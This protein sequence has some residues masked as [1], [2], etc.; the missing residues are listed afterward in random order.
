MIDLLNTSAG[1]IAR[2]LEAKLPALGGPSWWTDNVVKRLT[3]QQQRLVEEKK[4]QSITNLDLAAVLRVL[5]QNWGELAAVEPLPREARNWIKE[6][7][8]IRN[9]WAHA[10]VAGL[11]PA[12]TF[13]DADTLNRLMQVMRAESSLMERVEAFKLAALAK[14]AP[15][16]ETVSKPE[17]T[18]PSGKLA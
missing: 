17:A 1:I 12:D 2:W 5:D 3:F 10:P 15:L 9:R 8:S 6:L 18:C 14:L 13:R 16:Q 4:I 11:S 7:Q